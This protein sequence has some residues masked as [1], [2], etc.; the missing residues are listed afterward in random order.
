MPGLMGKKGVSLVSR[1]GLEEADRCPG[2]W[3]FC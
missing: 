2:H 1:S 3:A